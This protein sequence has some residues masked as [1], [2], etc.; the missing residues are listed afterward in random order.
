MNPQ[1]SVIIPTYRWRGYLPDTL[2]SVFRQTFTDF[3]V[4]VINDGSPDDVAALLCPLIESGRIRYFEQE[5][6]GPGA[7]RN[8]GIVEARGEFLAFLDDDDL[9]PEDSLQWR[10]A[11]LRAEA[12]AVLVYGGMS[13]FDDLTPRNDGAPVYPGA[14]SPSGDVHRD[15]LVRNWIHSSGQVLVRA[16]VIRSI[17]GFAENLYGVEDYDLWIR[18]AEKGSFIYDSRRSLFYRSHPDGMSRNLSRMHHVLGLVRKKHLGRF[19]RLA[20]WRL[21]IANYRF[22]ASV[23]GSGFTQAAEA[24][25]QKGD[26]KAA[27]RLWLGAILAM[28]TLLRRWTFLK[29]GLSLFC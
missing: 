22:W 28:P 13:L 5:N 26:K 19:P 15:F 2:D 24:S 14:D 17:H 20:T 25:L 29:I 7:A 16:S 3:E 1:V 4:I 6:A 9:W 27:R 23:T 21:W 12:G 10:V 18:I 8:R 11:R